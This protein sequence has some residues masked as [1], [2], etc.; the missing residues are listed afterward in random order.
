MIAA[1]PLL[2]LVAGGGAGPVEADDPPPHVAEDGARS[3]RVHLQLDADATWGIG[4]QMFLGA[5][6]RLAAVLEHWTTRRAIG[7]WDLGGA[8]AYQNE[9]TFL[10][11]WIDRDVVDGA[12]HRVILVAHVGHTVHMGARRRWALGL[13]LYGGANYWRSAYSVAYPGEA[14][15]GSAVVDRLLGV[16]GGELRLGY[17]FHR[18]VGANLAMGGPFPTSSSYGITLAHLGLGLSFFLR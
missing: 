18:R 17:R 2:M 11:P 14:V 15:S 7:T 10:A 9:P 12:G 4:A 5:Q 1:G 6:L 16:I 8:F 13:H 3:G